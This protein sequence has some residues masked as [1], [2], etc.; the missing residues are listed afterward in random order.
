MCIGQLV[1]SC[2]NTERLE[3]KL[4]KGSMDAGKIPANNGTPPQ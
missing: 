3:D 1:L 2:D 4:E